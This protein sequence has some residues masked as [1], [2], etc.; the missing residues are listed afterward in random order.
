MLQQGLR[1][2]PGNDAGKQCVHGRKG[3]D[4]RRRALTL[5]EPCQQQHLAP[6]LHQHLHDRLRQHPTA[7]ALVE[8][9]LHLLARLHGPRTPF[10]GIAGAL[11]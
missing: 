11:L 6:G 5:F 2:T 9:L 7:Q 4:P 10:F 3:V 1:I 8:Y